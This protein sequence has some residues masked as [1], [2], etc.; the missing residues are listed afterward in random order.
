MEILAL[1][2]S[3]IVALEHFYIMYLEMFA[4][5][6]N[7]AKRSFNLSDEFIE[8]KKVRVM[9][10]NQGLYNGF[11]GAFILLGIFLDNMILL[12]FALSC[13]IIAGIFG[14]FSANKSIFFKQALPSI[15]A[16]AL[17]ILALI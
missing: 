12:C 16:L 1:I 8:N 7:A 10:A 4:L 14:A 11:L 15:V 6:S 9:F 2:F 13:V 3:V 17:Q 5:S